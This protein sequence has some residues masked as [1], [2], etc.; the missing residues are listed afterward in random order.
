MKIEI[1]WLV[2]EHDCETCGSNWAQGA[3][4][5]FEDGTA[6]EMI[7]NAYCCGTEHYDNDEVYKAIIK[8]LGHEIVDVINSQE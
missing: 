5:G 6:I 8:K 3:K 7:P 4:V 2:D 1:E